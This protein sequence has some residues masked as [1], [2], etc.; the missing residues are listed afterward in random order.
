MSDALWSWDDLVAGTGATVEGDA[1]SG[2]SGVSI[3]SRTIKPGELYVALRNQLDGHDFV[4]AAFKAGAGAAL[5]ENGYVRK[6]GDGALLRVTDPL[7]AL[8]DLGR[9]ARKRSNAR[10]VAVTG[11]VGKTGTKDMLRL[12]LSE[13]GETHAAERSFNNHWGVPLTLARMPASAV[14]A[15]F[16]IGMN[17]AGEITP[18]VAMVRPHVVVITAIEP[19]HIGNFPNGIEGIAEAKAEILTGLVP[20]G[21]AALP[22]DNPHFGFLRDRANTVGAKI[23]TFGFDPDA[24]VRCIQMD[25]TPKGSSVIAG[26][27]TQRFSYKIGAPGEH[28]VRNSL[29]VLAVISALR[30]DAMRALKALSRVV[31]PAGRGERTLLQGPAGPLL[32]VDESFNANPASVRAA[33]AALGMTPRAENPRRIAVLGDMLEIGES[34]PDVHRALKEPVDA[35]GADL[36]FACGPMMRLLFETLD[37]SKQGGWAATSDELVVP[38]LER[39]QAGDV[40]M[41]KGSRGT[42]MGPIVEAVRRRFGTD[43]GGD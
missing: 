27:D 41:I 43:T 20:G 26:I 21:T 24:D 38:L 2:V 8:A 6:P 25:T 23:V 7:A 19:V 18:L 39:L 31:A 33:L 35:S 32:L 14:Y 9:A 5:V 16:E 40:V 4:G 12:A 36:V 11:S 10:I 3:D 29:A 34:S 30:A 28:Y 42:R 22:R 1:P 15:V 17:H 13:L 37:A